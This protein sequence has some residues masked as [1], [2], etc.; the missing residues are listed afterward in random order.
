MGGAI[1]L[2]SIAVVLMLRKNNYWV[3]PASQ[4]LQ[5]SKQ[6][7][8]QE[9]NNPNY[10]NGSNSFP[11]EFYNYS[12]VYRLW[13]LINE[14]RAETLKEAYSLLEQQYFYE[15]QMS[16]QEEIKCLQ[17]DIASAAKVSTV[18]TTLTAVNTARIYSKMK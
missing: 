6:V 4:A 7:F 2:G 18:A 9:A 5:E 15:D 11:E 1:I 8:S 16:I 12:D 17:Q 13:R 10:V 3:K 14:G